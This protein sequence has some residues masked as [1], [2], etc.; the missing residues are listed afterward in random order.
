MQRIPSVQPLSQSVITMYT[1]KCFFTT[2]I[3]YKELKIQKV[4]TVEGQ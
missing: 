2:V 3:H 1:A 4:A